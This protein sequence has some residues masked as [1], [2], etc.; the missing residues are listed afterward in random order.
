MPFGRLRP[1]SILLDQAINIQALRHVVGN[2]RD[3]PVRSYSKSLKQL[4]SRLGN[5]LRAAVHIRFFFTPPIKSHDWIVA[6][7]G[8]RVQPMAGE[9]AYNFLCRVCRT[10]RPQPLPELIGM[11]GAEEFIL[12]DISRLFGTSAESHGALAFLCSLGGPLGLAR[13]M[14]E[15]L[16]GLVAT[17]HPRTAFL[18][19]TLALVRRKSALTRRGLLMTTSTTWLAEALRVGLLAARS[20]MKVIEVL[21]GASTTSVVPYVGWVHRQAVAQPI[22]VNLIADLPRF[23]PQSEN[24]FTD[25]DGQIACNIR[26]WQERSTAVVNISSSK[27]AVP[28]IAF[29]GG[30]STDPR[31]ENSSFFRKEVAM[32][33]AL[34]ARVPNRIRYCVHPKYSRPQQAVLVEHVRALGAEPADLST[35]DEIFAARIV[36][37]GFSTSLIEAALLGRRAF[38]YEKIETLF[39]PEVAELV[40][41]NSDI[42]ILTGQIAEESARVLAQSSEIAFE[43]VSLLAQ[44]RYGL[45]LQLK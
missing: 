22:Y 20:D 45:T 30:A 39:I 18:Y 25:L 1:D 8:R 41:F 12:V 37:G 32:I 29:I 17:R 2:V 21:H 23:A 36:V 44:K 14:L 28:T 11:N 4:F 40:T 19:A 31:Y 24:L 9:G 13:L 27:F 34:K 43:T 16:V 10:N 5:A 33:K 38:S 7:D 26:L 3:K 15:L 42:D 6:F 35:Q